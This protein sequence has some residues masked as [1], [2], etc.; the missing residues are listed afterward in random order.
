MLH[1]IS[2][3]SIIYFRILFF[4]ISKALLFRRIAI[5]IAV[6]VIITKFRNLWLFWRNLFFI[7]LF[8]I[9]LNIFIR[10][11]IMIWLLC[12]VLI[13]FYNICLFF[14]QVLFYLFYFYRYWLWL[15][16]LFTISRFLTLSWTNISNLFVI[17]ILYWFFNWIYLCFI[18][19]LSITNILYWSR[20][21]TVP[22]W[23]YRLLFDTCFRAWL[24]ICNWLNSNILL[25]LLYR[26]DKIIYFF[27]LWFMAIVLVFLFNM[28]HLFLSKF[29]FIIIPN[30]MDITIRYNIFASHLQVMLTF[31]FVMKHNRIVIL[32]IPHLW[33]FFL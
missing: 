16:N 30:I 17:F 31:F 25:C 2:I 7:L 9:M 14:M 29:H 1:Q 18:V 11:Y 26:A 20:L 19:I 22:L 21:T 6:S 13:L 12:T 23:G 4:I 10:Y 24:L 5:A 15:W 8:V 28:F 3:R 33:L 27:I 32:A